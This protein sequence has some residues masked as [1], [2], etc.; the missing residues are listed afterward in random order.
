M[1]NPPARAGGRI[2]N[3]AKGS[4]RG[5]GRAQGKGERPEARGRA[6]GKEERIPSNPITRGREKARKISN[7]DNK[8][9]VEYIGMDISMMIGNRTIIDSM[10]M[11]L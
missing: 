6:K 10:S 9:E 11:S 8:E 7:R 5:E 1:G 3:P 2:P 4:Q